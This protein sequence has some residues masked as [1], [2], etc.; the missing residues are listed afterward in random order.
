M[1]KFI[2][3]IDV[4]RNNTLSKQKSSP[5]SKPETFNQNLI[6][7]N[8]LAA[9][10]N[11]PAN[12]ATRF[13]EGAI[14]TITDPHSSVDNTL[15]PDAE[16]LKPTTYQKKIT[17][18]LNGT[19]VVM[20]PYKITRKSDGQKRAVPLNSF[21]FS[22][23]YEKTV[24]KPNTSGTFKKSY[25]DIQFSNLQTFS[26]DVYKA[27]VFTKEK[28]SQGDYEKIGEVTLDGQNQLINPE[29]VTGFET[30]GIYHTQSIIEDGWVTSSNSASATQGEDDIAA[31]V[32]LSGSNAQFGTITGSDFTFVTKT[33]YGLQ[34]GEDYMVSFDAY[35]NKSNKADVN[36]D[37]SETAELEVYLTGS[38]ISPTM[39]SSEYSLGVLDNTFEGMQNK[40]QGQINGV[41]NYFKTHN[42][43]TL[44]ETKLGFRVKSGN[45]KLANVSLTPYFEKNFN[46]V[47]FRTLLPM[48]KPVKRGQRFDFYTEFYDFNN[49]KSNF[50]AETSASVIF[51]GAPEVFAQGTGSASGLMTG[52]VFLGSTTGSGI[53][54]HGGSAYMRSIGYDGFN[55]TI[56]NSLGGFIIFSGSVQSQIG[57]SETYEGVGL[58]IVDAHGDTNRFLKFKTNAEGTPS[59]FEIQTD[60]FFLGKEGQFIS[61]SNGNIIISSSNFFLGS[62]ANFVSG[63]NGNLKM[64]SS[65][66]HLGSGNESKDGALSAGAFISSSTTN[67]STGEG[68]LT[69]SSSNFHLSGSGRLNAGNGSFVV[70]ESGDVTLTG[71]ITAETGGTIGG[72]TIGAN[73]LSVGSGTTL[74]KIAS[75][76]KKIQIGAKASLTDSNAGVHI[77]TDGIALGASSV[78]KVT[79]AGVVTAANITATGGT[80]GGFTITDSKIESSDFVSG[81]KGIRISTEQNGLIEAENARIRGTLS[82]TTFEKE[83]VN[84]VGGQ[85]LIA[86]STMITGSSMGLNDTSASVANVS[87][88][89]T[90]EIL[91]IKEVSSTGFNTEYLRVHSASRDSTDDNNLTG[92]L[93]V[94]RSFSNTTSTASGSVGDSIGNSGSYEPGQVIVSTGLSGSG[95]IRINANPKDITTPYI[96]I[97]ERTG[98]G[99]YDVELKARLG[100][101]SGISNAVVGTTTPGFGLFSENV[102][103]TGTISASAGAIGGISMDSG[104]LFVGAGTHGNANT[105]F[106]MD[107][108]GKFSLKDKLVWNGSALTIAGSITITN[109]GDIDISDLNNDSGFTDDT[110]ANS[111]NEIFRQDNA[112]TAI[113]IGDLWYDTNDGNKLYVATATGTGD[114]EAT[115]DGTIATA[116]SAAD[117]AQSTAN[118]ANSAA[119][120][121]DGKAVTAQA[122]IDLMETRVVI[123]NT[124][125]ALKAKTDGSSGTL[126]GQ[127]IA[128]YGTTTTFF[129]GVASADANKK[130]ELNASGITLF[131]SQAGNDFL[132][133]EAGGI[134]MRSNNVRTLHITDNGINI[135]KSATG[136]SSANTPSAV[137]GNISLHGAGAR[138]YGAAVDDYVDVKSDGVD[139]VTANTTTAAFGATTTIGD[140]DHEHVRISGSGFELKDGSTQYIGMD[141][142][143]MSIG[144]NIV[145][146]TNGN[147]TFNGTVQIGGTSLDATNTLNTNTTKGN[148]GLGNVDNTSDATQQSNTLS[149][150]D[151]DD[152]GLGNVANKNEQT[153]AQDGMI[154]GVTLTGGGITIGTGGAIKSSGKD[155]LADTTNGFFLGTSDGGSSYDFAIGD[156][157]KSL[158]WDGSAS[159][160]EVTGTVTATAGEIGGWTID[161]TQLKSEDNS[162]ILD[163]GSDQ[164]LVSGSTFQGGDE[165]EV[166]AKLSGSRGNRAEGAVIVIE[167]EGIIADAADV[168]ILKLN[169]SQSYDDPTAYT[170][171]VDK[172]A[173]TCTAGS[174]TEAS[175]GVGGTGLTSGV[176]A[177]GT[178]QLFVRATDASTVTSVIIS[179]ATGS[180]HNTMIDSGE[181]NNVVELAFSNFV[182]F[183]D[184]LDAS[185]DKAQF[186]YK[187]ELFQSD[188]NDTREAE[189]VSA[190][191]FS[192]VLTEPV[193]SGVNIPNAIINKRFFLL[194]LSGTGYDQINADHGDGNQFHLKFT[195]TPIAGTQFLPKVRLNGLGF[196][197]YAGAN[198]HVTFGADNKIVGDM[199]V[200]ETSADS[201]GNLF[202]EGGMAIGGLE[203][204]SDNE[205]F[206]NGDIAATGNITAFFT[207]DERLKN[208]VIT[209]DDGL[210]IINQLRP[211]EFEWDE[212]S[213]FYHDKF[214]D[215]GLIAQEVEKVLPNIVGEMK[216]GYKGVKYEKLIPFLIDSIQQLTR[217]V[218]ELEDK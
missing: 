152:V 77:G 140:T 213:P 202:V 184:D 139:I 214:R 135:G 206:V 10:A 91:M 5:I 102:F 13:L 28:G 108:G 129:D 84:A 60:T 199:F 143:G 19:N 92:K 155:S 1:P 115:V 121:A 215:Y 80:I 178:N 217:R 174:T 112:P 190:H 133:L 39:T 46:P 89:T 69:I 6:I 147:A 169:T 134:E 22:I 63:S 131:G 170:N 59:E 162:I 61:G 14:L 83:S 86:N 165:K 18:V 119:S 97:V 186:Q 70:D 58:E 87:G 212:E 107:S 203:L 118:T 30:I 166:R 20:P 73:D 45:F 204:D 182:V 82:T 93:F 57:A 128:E 151:A 163:E 95:Y 37:V 25:A 17:K 9:G 197:T 188:T 187:I 34:R 33:S 15:Y 52:S 53:E 218:K 35:F 192:D 79:N 176:A 65:A 71:V 54:L 127:T 48:P 11:H 154:S 189:L 161:S 122:A 68:N 156:G 210:S 78:F 100:D 123:D 109:P 56:S 111:K 55:D 216:D 146:A 198:Q 88:F 8:T 62:Q 130:L 96:D 110:T 4:V 141:A 194:R 179:S 2:D 41:F 67:S 106:F 104:S 26:G 201:R 183:F 136:P 144:S 124:G 180:S 90:G 114:W 181:A 185:G 16:F 42:K 27:K 148:V 191:R 76:D 43:V 3:E 105:A 85:L 32:L 153:T 159:T 64:S 50:Q 116:Q 21:A 207:S 149:A 98:S 209:I 160:L 31:S 72:F 81:L 158:K 164:I 145:L 36:G 40:T 24:V 12:K 7:I 205:L 125:M 94:T 49:N 66:F 103:L 142:N 99:V 120:T 113:A 38:A 150:A 74:V 171:N 44:P 211:V 167:R 75:N 177:W 47:S 23:T 172:K 29:G 193:E 168:Q 173:I 138:I 117:S 195:G 132:F 196:Q 126:N 137:I 51:D 175:I 200:R 157:T 101:L 208:N